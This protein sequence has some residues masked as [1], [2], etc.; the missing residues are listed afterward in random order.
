MKK[1]EINTKL[2]EF[3]RTLSPTESERDVVSDL[4]ASFQSL[5]GSTNCL[6]VG[7][8]PRFTAVTPIHDLDILYVI[9]EWH[10]DWPTDS[11]TPDEV[12]SQLVSNI[13]NSFVKPEGSRI[14]E[15][16]KQTHSVS[17]VFKFGEQEISVDVVP[18]YSYGT[19]EFGQPTY[20]VPEL[21][22]K[23]SHAARR[24][25]YQAKMANAKH[26]G[27]IKSDPRGYISVATAVGQNSDFR[28]AVKIIKYWKHQLVQA[29]KNLKLKS[30]HLEQVVTLY[31]Q[32]NPGGT[33]FDAL[34]TFF[35]DFPNTALVANQIGDRANPHKFIDDYIEKLSPGV[36]EK[37]VEARDSV[38]INFESVDELYSIRD[39]FKPGFR[40]RRDPLEEYLFDNWIPVL[41]EPDHDT[42]D[43][44]AD[45]TNKQGSFVRAFLRVGIIDS[46]R[47]LRFKNPALSG[48]EFKWKV[49]NDDSCKEPRGEITNNRTKNVPENTKYAGRHYVECYAVREGICVAKSRH[50]VIIGSGGTPKIK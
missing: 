42:F 9:G 33:I 34:F 16:N 43:I 21:L 6:Q 27:W 30:L 40:R 32:K 2:R 41:L 13:K 17:V 23:N 3:A 12:I 29:N 28:K 18:A 15:I 4:Y 46:G 10:T 14:L 19:N 31:F 25:M 39:V 44:S 8:Y 5:L 7:S 1:S 49:K 26:V 48:C 35:V 36:R 47:Y 50:D 22:K 24:E 45:I 20:R 37:F 38:L 11:Y